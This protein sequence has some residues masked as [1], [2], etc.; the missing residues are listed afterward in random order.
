MKNIQSFGLSLI[1]VVSDIEETSNNDFN[2][3]K[4]WKTT[5]IWVV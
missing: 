1:C 3:A 2:L 5:Y 4:Q